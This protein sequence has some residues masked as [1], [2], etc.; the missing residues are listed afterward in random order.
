MSRKISDFFAKNIAFTIE[1]RL[2]QG[3]C[4]TSDTYCMILYQCQNME[5]F[6]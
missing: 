6:L 3:Y 4:M 1:N 2:S 5:I